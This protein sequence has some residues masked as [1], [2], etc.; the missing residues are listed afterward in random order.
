MTSGGV[1]FPCPPWRTGEHDT[2]EHPDD[3]FHL[4][5]PEVTM[6]AGHGLYDDDPVPVRVHLKSWV[7][8]LTAEPQPPVIEVSA[9]RDPGPQMTPDQARHLAGILTEFAELA[10]VG[11]RDSPPS[12]AG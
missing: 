5:A 3:G 2:P 8:R 10:E 9:D 12:T 1:P 7:P 11:Q 4:C 6:T